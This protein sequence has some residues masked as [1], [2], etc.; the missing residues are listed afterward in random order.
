MRI[1]AI[2][3]SLERLQRGDTAHVFAIVEQPGHEIDF[4]SNA[5]VTITWLYR[6]DTDDMTAL[7]VDAVADASLPDG[8]FD[9]FVHAEAAGP[10]LNN[11]TFGAALEGLGEFNLPGSG[12]STLGNGKYDALDDLRLWIHDNNAADD[13]P[14]FIEVGG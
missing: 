7:L 14:E 2:G 5:D 6:T 11:A 8:T 1:G 10:N 12:T 9:V 3:A 13:E 4:P